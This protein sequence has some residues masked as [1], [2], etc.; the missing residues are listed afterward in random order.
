MLLKL[1][2]DQQTETEKGSREVVTEK[3]R[4]NKLKL[5]ELLESTDV[6]RRFLR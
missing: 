1:Q 4:R 5:L 3:D 2:S 6:C